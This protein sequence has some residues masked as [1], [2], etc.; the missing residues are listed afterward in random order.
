[1]SIVIT[2]VTG[3]LGRHVVE[4]LLERHVPADQIVAT[5]RSVEKIADLADRGVQVKKMDYSDAAS[6]A[7]ALEG[8]T[9]VLLVSGSDV[10]QRVEQHRTVIEAAQRAGVE[11]IAYTSVANAD[12][13]QMKLAVDHV[14]TENIVKE[15]GVPFV[16]L[17]NG[18]YLENYTDQLQGT[19]AQGALAGSA[20]EGRV[21]AAT[22]ADYAEAAAAVL[23]A[24]DQEG[25]IYELGND[26]PFTMD[27]LAAAIS[28]ASGKDVSYQNLPADEYTALLVSVG[29]PEAFAEVLA[30]SDLGIA[31]GDLLVNSGDLS[32]LLGRP[33]TTMADAV[34]AATTA[35]LAESN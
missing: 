7:A 25:K 3:H 13:S 32:K 4:S 2:G 22:R 9:K 16:F 34:R 12:S 5:G 1:M 29:L 35:V 17:R 24:E 31:R 8:A 33:T 18:W 30:D 21:S 19:L 26:T 15:S 28:D 20:G 23:V 11:L 6:V 14:A 10:G 27:E